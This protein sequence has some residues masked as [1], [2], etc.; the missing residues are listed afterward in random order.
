MWFRRPPSPPSRSDRWTAFATQLGAEP[1]GD[2]AERLRRFLD[3]DDAEVRD[4]HVLRRPGAP[5]LFLFDVVRRRSGPL[6]QVVR[7]SSWALLRGDRPVSAV[8]FRA[9]PRREA[10]LESLEASRTGAVRVDL[11]AWPEVDAR[12]AVLARDAAA[13]R[14][15]LTP[16]VSAALG[17]LLA[18]G[19]G[20]AVGG[21]DSAGPKLL[22]KLG[23]GVPE[24][25]PL[26]SCRASSGSIQRMSSL[27]NRRP[28]SSPRDRKSVV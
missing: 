12:L 11:S 9:A 28:S 6:G 14:S 2:A 26:L 16:V 19:P 24:A 7:W 20:A 15:L 21:A 25:P 8:S 1:A 3:L 17:D 4:V 18:R 5:S 13:A 23:S 10:V 22:G 27:P